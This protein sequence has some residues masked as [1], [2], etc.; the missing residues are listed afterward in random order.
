MGV[1]I[2]RI[3]AIGAIELKANPVRLASQ[4]GAWGFELTAHFNVAIV[5]SGSRFEYSSKSARI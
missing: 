3:E 5:C 1:L 2:E 4:I